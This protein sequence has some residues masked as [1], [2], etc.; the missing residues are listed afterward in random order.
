M[1]KLIDLDKWFFV[2]INKEGANNVFDQVMPY[3]RQPYVWAPFYLFL[4]VFV[5]INFKKKALSWILFIS[6]TAG[7]TDYTSSHILKPWIARLRPC[8]DPEVISNIRLLA[9]YCGQNGSFT[10]SHAA[11]HFGMAMFLFITLRPVWGNG[12]WLFFLWATL[13]CYSQ[14][15]VGVHFPLDVIGGAVLGCMAGF[16][17]AALFLKKSGPL[18]ESVN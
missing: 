12:C 3:L 7:I 13:I 15:Y 17:T 11:N 10:S 9:S 1:K 4:L 5:L 16:F 14:V 8:N 2:K 6:E 18:N